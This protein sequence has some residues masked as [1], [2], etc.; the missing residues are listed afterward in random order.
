MSDLGF[1]KIA[2]AV[3]ATGLAIAGLNEVSNHAFEPHTALC[4]EAL[5]EAEAEGHHVEEAGYCITPQLSGGAEE[6]ALPVQWATILPVANIAAGEVAFAK[7]TSCHKPDAEDGTGPGL[8]GVMGR[9][10]GTKA[11]FTKYSTAMVEFGA[12]HPQWDFD[13][14]F[15][16]LYN[17]RREVPGTAMSFNGIR[18]EEERIN[19]IAYLNTLGSG[20]PVP[21]FDPT[22]E[23]QPEGEEGEGEEGAEGEETEGEDAAEGEEAAAE[24]VPAE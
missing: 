22:R 11:S 8:E 21:E 1:N 20:L 13:L 2:G 23:P 14:V 3:L 17:P 9:Q 24:E 12:E 15:D 10:P 5:A 7:C 16:Y 4:G 6:E 19:L 18:G